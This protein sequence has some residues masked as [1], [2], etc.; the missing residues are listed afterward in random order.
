MIVV[1]TALLDRLSDEARRTPRLRKNLNFHPADDYPCHRFLNAVEPGTYIRPHRHLD[2]AKDESLAVLR[3]KVGIITFDERG[4]VTAAV[5]LE[6]GG[7][8]RVADIPHGEYHAAVSL[9]T[10]TVFLEAKGGP[11]LPLT[12]QE[13][14]PWAPAEGE[15]AA[16]PY[17][18]ALEELFR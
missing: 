10:G 9:E 14:A 13:T 11:Y 8:A 3:G 17:L 7:A 15:P 4:M 2:P 18:A 16:A 1:D 6:P 5:L 12:D